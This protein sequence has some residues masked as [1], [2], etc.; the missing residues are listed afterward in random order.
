MTEFEIIELLKESVGGIT[1]AVG[2][3]A[4][5]LITAIFLRNNT[6]IKQF[7]KIKAGRFNEVTE[8]LLA[9]GKMTYTEFYKSKNFLNIARKPTSI[10]RRN[11]RM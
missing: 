11:C 6:S 9:F 7:E 3:M 8:E 5:S 4:G 2:A 10:L 1:T